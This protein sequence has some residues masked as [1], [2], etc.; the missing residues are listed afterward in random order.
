MRK[1]WGW[2]L[3]LMAIA[4]IRIVQL[5]YVNYPHD[6]TPSDLIYYIVAVGALFGWY[7]LAISSP[8]EGNNARK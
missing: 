1:F 3:F 4:T 6:W 5:S 7:R 8:Q 2:L